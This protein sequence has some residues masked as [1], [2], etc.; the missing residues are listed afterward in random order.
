MTT[1]CCK[2]SMMVYTADVR[3]LAYEIS[4]HSAAVFCGV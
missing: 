3:I 2:F 4:D 1:S